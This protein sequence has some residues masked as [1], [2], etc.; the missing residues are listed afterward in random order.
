MLNSD[1]VPIEEIDPESAQDA[2]VHAVL[3][4]GA[5]GALVLA[6]IAVAVVMALWFAFYLLVFMPRAGAP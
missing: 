2:T 4:S 5:T 1:P 6:G 3:R